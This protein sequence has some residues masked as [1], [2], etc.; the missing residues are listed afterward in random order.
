[1]SSQRPITYREVFKMFAERGT[2]KQNLPIDFR[3]ETR[4]HISPNCSDELRF[5]VFLYGNRIAT[6]YRDGSVRISPGKYRTN[7][8]KN[9]LNDFLI[10]IGWKIIERD[11]QWKLRSI[12]SK[13][14]EPILNNEL[15]QPN[16]H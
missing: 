1:M 7:T 2:S 4:I 15:V 11:R 6:L 8:T 5:E 10:P 9:R 13:E 16:H 3:R 14:E 12:E